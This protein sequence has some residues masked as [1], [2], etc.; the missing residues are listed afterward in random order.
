VTSVVMGLIKEALVPLL[1][2]VANETS[3]DNIYI[4]VQLSCYLEGLL[5]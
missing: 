2:Y 1:F 3:D 4:T 5:V